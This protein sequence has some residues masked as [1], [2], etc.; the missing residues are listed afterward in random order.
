MSGRGGGTLLNERKLYVGLVET[1]E[2]KFQV[3]NLAS[4]ISINPLPSHSSPSQVL[5]LVS[6]PSKK[7]SPTQVLNVVSFGWKHLLNEKELG[8]RSGVTGGGE[9][10]AFHNSPP[11]PRTKLNLGL[12]RGEIIEREESKV[13]NFEWGP[14]SKFPPPSPPSQVLNVH[15]SDL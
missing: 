8:L 15:H 6:F 10:G 3:L 7:F 11:P 9:G 4:S 14:F 12:G 1:E 13:R 2:T 5:N